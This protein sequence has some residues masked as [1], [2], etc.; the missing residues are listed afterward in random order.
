MNVVP[1]PLPGLFVIEPRAFQDA[2]GWFLESFNERAFG[3]AGLNAT[4]VQANHSHSRLGTVRGLHFQN[5]NPQIKL[6]RVVQ[7]EVFDVV[8]DVRRGSPTFGRSFSVT[9]SAANRRQ[10]WVPVGFAHGFCVTSDA[11]DFTYMCSDF[12]APAKERGIRWD[13]PALQIAWPTIAG[14]GEALVVSPKDQALPTLAEVLASDPDHLPE[15]VEST[16]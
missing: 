7:G 1:T 8:V 13:D 15:W 3:A 12:Y 16:G 10:L 11:A 9:L 14:N 5:P 6:V 4:M 2:R